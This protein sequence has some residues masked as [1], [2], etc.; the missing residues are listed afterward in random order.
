[1]N[2]TPTLCPGCGEL[3]IAWFSTDGDSLLLPTHPDRVY[4]AFDCAAGSQ[5]AVS[6]VPPEVRS[7]ED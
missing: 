2:A 7:R 3:V 4:P 5:S 6:V 1:M